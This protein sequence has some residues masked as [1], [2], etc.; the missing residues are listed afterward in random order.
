MIRRQY[1]YAMERTNLNLNKSV[2]IYIIYKKLFKVIFILSD[3]LQYFC[4]E[5]AALVNF[6]TSPLIVICLYLNLHDK[7]ELTQSS[8]FPLQHSFTCLVTIVSDS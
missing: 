5:F 6:I 7:F 4:F 2:S 1:L 8:T 3:T